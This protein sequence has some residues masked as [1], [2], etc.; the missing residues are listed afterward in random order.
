MLQSPFDV[1]AIISLR[2]VKYNMS[3]CDDT[4]HTLVHVVGSQDLCPLQPEE[5]S[6]YKLHV[7][8]K[9]LCQ[10]AATMWYHNMHDT[11]SC[12]LNE[13]VKHLWFTFKIRIRKIVLEISCIAAATTNWTNRIHATKSSKLIMFSPFLQHSA[14]HSTQHQLFHWTPKHSPFAFLAQALRRAT[15]IELFHLPVDHLGQYCFL[16]SISTL[17]LRLLYHRSSNELSPVET[18][19]REKFGGSLP[20]GPMHLHWREWKINKVDAYLQADTLCNDGDID[21]KT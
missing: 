10:M 9:Q 11:S 5:H 8:K 13:I 7:P 20:A 1:N 6:F 19:L 4:Y 14:T 18:T 3:I 17:W 16:P 12:F 2:D 21:I 15:P